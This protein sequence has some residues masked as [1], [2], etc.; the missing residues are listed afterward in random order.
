MILTVCSFLPNASLGPMTLELPFINKY[1]GTHIRRIRGSQQ[2]AL[3]AKEA[4]CILACMTTNTHSGLREV[5][6]QCRAV[7][8]R[9]KEEL[10]QIQWKVTKLVRQLGHKPCEE[11]VLREGGLFRPEKTRARGHPLPTRLLSRSWSQVLYSSAWQ[12]DK[13]QLT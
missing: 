1:F 12:E 8:K 7:T 6:V 5:I 3:A 10:Q 2:R 11:R 4:S 13:R 9:Q